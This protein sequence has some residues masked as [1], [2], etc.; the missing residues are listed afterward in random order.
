MMKSWRVLGFLL[1]L[2]LIVGSVSADAPTTTGHPASE[3][4]SIEYV[5][6]YSLADVGRYVA[7]AHHPTTGK[8]YISYYDDVNAD[9]V[10][11]HEVTPGTGN[12]PSNANWKCEAVDTDTLAGKYTSID[13][14]VVPANPP[15]PSYTKIAISYYHESTQSLR[16]AIYASY[17]SPGWT[18]HTVDDSTLVNNIRGT[19]TSLKFPEGSYLPM[20]AYHSSSVLADSGSVKIANWV[21]S[22][23]GDCGDGNNWHCVTVASSD[24]LNYGSHVSMDINQNDGAAYIAF[25]EPYYGS[26]ILAHYQGFGGSCSNPEYECLTIDELNHPGQY[27]SLHAPDNPSDVM[28]LVYYDEDVEWVKY[29]EYVGSGGNCYGSTAYDCYYLDFVGMPPGNIGLAQTVDAQGLPIIVYMDAHVATAPA[30]LRI[31]RPAAAY[32]EESGNCGELRDGEILQYWICDTIDNGDQ[33]ADEAQFVAVS[34]SPAGLAT[35]AYSEYNSYDDET[36][37]KVAKQHFM[38]YMPIIIR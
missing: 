29:A 1:I 16:V 20:V 30:Q 34:V 6:R 37:L 25:Y 14:T 19:Y 3:P 24:D 27:L 35:I 17:P 5:S 4:W 28:R 11:A 33:Y 10:M 22:G 15:H 32:G 21:G 36:Y 38:A 7:I 12:C 18:I 26:V 9:L 23:S 2:F 8:A 13:V 31:A